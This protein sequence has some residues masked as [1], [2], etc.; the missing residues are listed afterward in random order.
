MAL[1]LKKLRIR[2]FAKQLLIYSRL[3]VTGSSKFGAKNNLLTSSK[4]PISPCVVG[5]AEWREVY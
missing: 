4:T 5:G 3:S 1:A 2:L